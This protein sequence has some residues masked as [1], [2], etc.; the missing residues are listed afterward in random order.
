MS[1]L[2]RVNPSSFSQMALAFVRGCVSQ[3]H[4]R[5]LGLLVWPFLVSL[6]IWALSAWLFW[7]PLIEWLKSSWMLGNRFVLFAGGWLAPLGISD[8]SGGLARGVAILLLLPVILASAMTAIA[9]FA[10]PIVTRHLSASHYPTLVRKGSFSLW[11][12]LANALLSIS[13]FVCGYLLTLPLW[14]IPPLALV[15]PW[16]WWGWLTARMM[17]FD[18]LVEHADPDERNLLIGRYKR[19]YLA[20]GLAVAALNV[21]HHH[22]GAFCA[23]IRP[24]LDVA[25]R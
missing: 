23:G 5:M 22:A 13:V 15:V 8:L 7:D 4:P 21:V 25:T 18:S 17:R 3:L 9:V 20:L 16:L 10:M 11:A 14:F 6:I 1:A 12:N 24:F 19:E 2:P